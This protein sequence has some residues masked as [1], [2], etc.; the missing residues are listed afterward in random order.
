MGRWKSI[1]SI[2][3]KVLG[4][5]LGQFIVHKLTDTVGLLDD[6]TVRITDDLCTDRTVGRE[7][8]LRCLGLELD[9]GFDDERV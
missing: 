5:H 3:S 4:H 9:S 7:K 6:L 8:F 1:R 2:S